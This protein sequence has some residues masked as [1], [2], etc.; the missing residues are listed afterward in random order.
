VPP[1]VVKR[2]VV[3]GSRRREF[4]VQFGLAFGADLLSDEP[5]D[6]KASLQAIHTEFDN[7]AW[8]L[9]PGSI[10]AQVCKDPPLE[11]YR[12]CTWPEFYAQYKQFRECVRSFLR[13]PYA[14][15]FFHIEGYRVQKIDL[16]GNLVGEPFFTPKEDIKEAGQWRQWVPQR[17]TRAHSKIAGKCAIISAKRSPNMS[18]LYAYVMTTPIIEVRYVGVW[19][20][21]VAWHRGVHM[22]RATESLAE[23]AGSVLRHMDMKWKG[24]HPRHVRQLICAANLRMA[25]L[26]GVGGRGRFLDNGF[27]H[28]LQKKWAGALA[29]SEDTCQI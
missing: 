21:I 11:V 17:G 2:S 23:C 14:G 18:K 1:P 5:R 22:G 29:F 19:N 6:C 16:G 8:G 4:L 3:G 9:S 26:R 13:Y 28:A 15:E 7:K 12:P 10:P 25:G 20:V 24:C 27:E